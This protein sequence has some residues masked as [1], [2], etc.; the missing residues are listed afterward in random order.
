MKLL[1]VLAFG[2]LS[3]AQQPVSF[4]RDIRPI[5]ADTCFRCHGPDKSSRMAGLRLDLREEA[6]KANRAGRVPVVPGDASKSL[7]MDRIFATSSAKVM[8]PVSIHKELTDKQKDVIRRWINE[9]AVYE[10]HWAYQPIH[11]SENGSIDRFVRA[12]LLEEGLK[13]AAEADRRTLLRR[14]TLDLT[15]LPPTPAEINQ[16]LA[17]SSANAYEKAVDRLLAS[18][19]YAEKMTMHWLDAVRY[20]DTAGFHGDNLFPA[21]PYR[22]YVLN[23]F[24]NNKPFDA[25]TREQL[26][27]DLIPNA[28]VDQKVAAAFNRLNRVS[29]EG[30]LQP[31]EYLAKYGADRVRT[32]SAVW[33]GAT[34]GCAE[35]HDHKFDPLLAKDFYAMKAFFAD[36]KE[37]GLVPDRGTAAWGA[38]M[39]MPQPDQKQK[40]DA[41]VARLEAARAKL[42]SPTDAAWEQR[43]LADYD[44]G[45][46]AW[47]VQ[48]PLTASSK[49]GATLKIYNEEEL[50]MMPYI[51]G[52]IQSFRAPGKGLIVASG[53]NPDRETYTV[54]F[55]P[56]AGSWTALGLEV[57]QDDSLLSNAVARGSDRLVISEIEA[58]SSASKEPIAFSLATSNVSDPGW[59]QPPLAAI[60]GDPKT[61]WGV[62]TYGENKNLMLALRLKQPLRT[63]GSETITVTL[64]HDSD[65]RKATIGRFRL[66][67]S[68]GTQSW[69]QGSDLAKELP[70]GG[71]S[72]EVLKALRTEP[73]KRSDAQKKALLSYRAW[74]DPALLST[75]EEIARLEHDRYYLNA[76]IPRVLAVEQVPPVETRILPRGNFLDETG[77]VVEPAIPVKFGTLETGGRRATRLDLANWIV[78]QDNPLTARVFVNR[79]WRQFFGAGLTK[80]LDDLGS[81]GELPSNLDLLDWLAADFQSHWDV[82][83]AV[84]TIV[85]SETY[86]QSSIPSKEAAEKDPENRLFA[87]QNRIR[88]DA[89]AVHDIALSASGLL[90]ERF[91]GPSVRPYQPEGYLGALNFPKRDYAASIGKDLYARG[92]YTQW[93]RTFLHPSL[94]AFDAPSREECTV[95][96]VNSNTPLQALVLLNDPI[97][98]E[99]ARVFAQKMLSEGGKSL[100]DRLDWAFARALGRQAAPEE[101][102]ILT[103]LYAANLKR[104]QADSL[105]AKQLLTVGDAPLA[106]KV[107]PEEL[108]AAM[109][110]TRAILNLHETITRN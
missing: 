16:F 75:W 3:L 10:G 33:L 19:A 29:A 51:G 71:L 84:K 46:L 104:F 53:A 18:K 37:T 7:I 89:E 5:M 28:T 11:K 69:P 83:R 67:L 91:G 76:A 63:N 85:M 79:L 25:F 23:S 1:V 87:R 17:D 105:A 26:A 39:T 93:Q 35:C 90:T 108:A 58:K 14:V 86:R 96:R 73:A 42:Q 80:V 41:I 74:A 98:V 106:V 34:L 2:S 99:A 45:K 43:L 110:V 32:V 48:R 27:G 109:T 8:P 13:P 101:K 107:K 47:Q 72:D 6:T 60:D 70:K 15:G 55:Q 30:G 103:E 12:R 64:R 92:L 31:K 44:A 49:N 78:S 102:Q 81:Q 59:E 57:V 100:G 95:N 56:K 24:L 61:G 66:A 88:V 9:G 94:M 22:D 65:T 50:D 54:T 4:N 52:I 77:P 38:V 82:K 20:A 68:A 62:V 97:Y 36:I 40:L 21:W